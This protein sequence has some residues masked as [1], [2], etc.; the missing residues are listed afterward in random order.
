MRINV[1]KLR[2][3]GITVSV[4]E[5]GREVAFGPELT[6]DVFVTQGR[7]LPDGVIDGIKEAIS[8]EMYQNVVLEQLAET[9]QTFQIIEAIKDTGGIE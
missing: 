6:V 3:R 1:K 7:R 4:R 9:V 2:E 5:A 8:N